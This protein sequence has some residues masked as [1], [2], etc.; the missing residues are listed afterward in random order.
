[1]ETS[2]DSSG[3]K[4]PEV[5]SPLSSFIIGLSGALLGLGCTKSRRTEE[6]SFDPK[7]KALV[8]S[9]YER[10][11]GYFP[12]YLFRT[13]ENKAVRFYD[14]LVKGKIV[15]INFMMTTCKGT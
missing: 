12:N 2:I 7:P 15:L 10:F 13:Q 6:E 8:V 9:P 5:F 4:A 1:M 3:R 14:D 11:E